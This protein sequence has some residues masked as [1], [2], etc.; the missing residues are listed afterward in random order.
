VRIEGRN[1][2]GEEVAYDLEGTPARIVQHELDHLDGHR[3]PLNGK[4]AFVVD[5]CFAGGAPV[6]CPRPRGASG[7]VSSAVLSWRAARRS[8]TSAPKDAVAATAN[9]I[10]AND[11]PGPQ[12]CKRF[13]AGLRR[14][15]VQDQRSVEV[16]EL[17][18][19]DAG[20][21]F[22]EVVPNLLPVR[23]TAFDPYRGGPLDGH[24]DAL[25]GE[26]AF[27][28]RFGFIATAD[29]LRIDEHADPVV[30][31]GEDEDA[32]QD[33]DLRGSEADAVR[34]LHQLAQAGGEPLQVVVELLH[35]RRLHPQ[36]GVGILA[37]L[38]EGKLAPCLALSLAL[39]IELFVPNFSF[40]LGHAST[41]AA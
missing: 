38:G 23:V 31:E 21:S 10:S 7:L 16:V 19:H 34:V 27:V 28:V 33:S 14:R 22:F 25:N 35:G 13:A 29:D 37:N 1:A 5:V 11:E 3:H 4:A 41:L 15:A 6:F 12:R 30:P 24:R 20:G 36:D 8:S 39:G 17:V 26:A 32:T 18:L 2:S 40:D 9:F